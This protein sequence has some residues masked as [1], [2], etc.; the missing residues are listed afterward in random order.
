MCMGGGGDSG[1]A[2]SRRLEDER[3]ARIN[4]GMSSIDKT[5]G[6]FNDD[7]YGLFEKQAYDLQ[8]PDLNRNYRK[9][10]DDATY[11]LARSGMARSS[12][13]ANLFGDLKERYGQADLKARDDARSLASERR[14][15]VEGS[16]N[17][18]VAQ[19]NATANPQA[20]AQSSIA[21]AK[22]LTAPPVY[23]PI[24]NAFADF[25]GLFADAMQNRRSGAPGWWQQ[26]GSSGSS[27]SG[28]NGSVRYV[29]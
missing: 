24:T 3:N 17:N 23:S 18:M 25:S 8:R 15:Q 26:I 22:T 14:Q 11:G 4:E 20:V 7:Y 5:Y 19:L 28:N 1:A 13:A 9:A 2:E 16:R 21:Q 27:V 6:D 12:A 10:T 29:P